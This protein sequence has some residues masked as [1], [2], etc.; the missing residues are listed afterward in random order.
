MYTVLVMAPFVLVFAVLVYAVARRLT[1]SWVEH[2]VKLAVLE[3]VEQNPE[4][5][6]SFQDLEE[7]NAS[8]SEGGRHDFVLTGAVLAL[9][10]GATILIALFI[11]GSGRMAVGAYFGGVACVVLGFILAL[12]GFLVRFLSRAPKPPA[13]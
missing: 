5:L 7:A 4:L 2:R 1:Q 9:I 11:M 13:A 12:L 6:E 3:R 8:A 10:G